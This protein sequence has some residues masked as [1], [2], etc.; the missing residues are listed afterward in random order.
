MKAL[1]FIVALLL[2]GALY[3]GLILMLASFVNQF[4]FTDDWINAKWI[5]VPV[6]ALA[7]LI[8]ASL[9]LPKSPWRLGAL[10]GPALPL[11]AFFI[12]YVWLQSI[13]S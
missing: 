7:I 2:S 9:R 11:T 4:R 12:F 13:Y 3:V 5:V 8:L 1:K 10:F 6:V